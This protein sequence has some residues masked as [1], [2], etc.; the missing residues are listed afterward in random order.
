[1]IDLHIGNRSYAERSHGSSDNTY[2]CADTTMKKKE[3]K[4]EGRLRFSGNIRQQQQSRGWSNIW[5]CPMNQW[6]RIFG[7]WR[8]A[9]LLE[10]TLWWIY[11]LWTAQSPR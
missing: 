2:T 6:D 8:C 10:R 1:M 7:M 11:Q 9:D 3:K 4:M 5:P